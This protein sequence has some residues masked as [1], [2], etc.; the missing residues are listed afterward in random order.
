MLDLH[1]FALLE[2]FSVS[3]G[4]SIGVDLV[5]APLILPLL[6]PE[7][8]HVL[9]QVLSADVN[10]GSGVRNSETLIDRYSVCN[11]VS[12][13][14]DCSGCSSSGKKTHDS[15]ISEVELGY[16]VLFKK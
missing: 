7:L 10:F 13:V 15:L 6:L 9:S 14:N 4:I 11:T 2:D 16:L 8:E 12:R 5:G 1:L 3:N